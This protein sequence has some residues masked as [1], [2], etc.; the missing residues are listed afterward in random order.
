MLTPNVVPDFT[1]LRVAVVGDLIVDRYV[2]ARPARLSGVRALRYAV[3]VLPSR[4]P[5]ALPGP[6]SRDEGPRRRV[7]GTP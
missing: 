4:E 3:L 6:P 2:Y 1:A 7:E 5:G